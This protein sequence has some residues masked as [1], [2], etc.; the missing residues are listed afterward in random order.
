MTP[1]SVATENAPDL[2]VSV[3]NDEDFEEA[4]GIDDFL[5]RVK[6]RNPWKISVRHLTLLSGNYRRGSRVKH[7]IARQLADR[8]L[9]S[10][11]PFE[12]AGYWGEVLIIDPR[13]LA[14]RPSA[15][16]ALPISSLRGESTSLDYVK[17]ED[18]IDTAET[19]MVLNDF[20]QLPVLAAQGRELKGSISW[21]SI[22][23]SRIHGS[24]ES[25]LDAMIPGGHVAE[26]TDS[27]MDLVPIILSD[28]YI[29]YRNDERK[30]VGVVTAA[31]LAATFQDTTGVFIRISEIEDR[32]RELLDTIPLPRL[33]Q[34]L[35]PNIDR[36]EGDFMGA[37][38]MTFGEY[39]RA[40]EDRELWNSL[41]LRY[42]RTIC[43]ENLRTVNK[44][45][46]DIMHFRMNSAADEPDPNMAVAQC[47]NWLRSC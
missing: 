46:N 43:V 47:L 11:P 5:D 36:G 33:Q 35:D 19:K 14:F 16:V 9:V 6:I 45:R 7:F 25:V 28:E 10:R 38:D 23:S 41:G 18:S 17:A 2:D 26:S 8:G 4:A 27:L 1:Q 24:P 29:F 15:T 40:L 30:I 37:S 12:R 42:N 21:R 22:A 39:V 44:V 20:S 31:D 13:D 34:A 3:F 32:I